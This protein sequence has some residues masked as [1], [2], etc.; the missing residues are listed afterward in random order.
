MGRQVDNI[1]AMVALVLGT[2]L[3]G[4]AYRVIRPALGQLMDV[5][6]PHH[7]VEEITACLKEFKDEF[8]EI[9][10]IRTRRSGTE[11]HVDIHLMVPGQTTVRAAHDLA[12]RIESR[13]ALRLPGT[14][15]L[16][17]IEP[18]FA[19]ALEAYEAR[20][21]TGAVVNTTGTPEEREAGH[22]GGDPTEGAERP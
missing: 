11:R 6:L 16:V 9:H 5:S 17:H 3:L 8:V 18:A 13:L 22:H 4:V 7:E 21:R 15:L 10:A 14:R 20:H 19:A 2:Y 1:D 12:H